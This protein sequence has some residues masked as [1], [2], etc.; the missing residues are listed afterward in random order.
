MPRLIQLYIGSVITLNTS[1]LWV[2]FEIGVAVQG[3][4]VGNDRLL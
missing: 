4:A 3:P 1:H 2:S